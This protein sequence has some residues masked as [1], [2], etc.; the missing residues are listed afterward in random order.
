VTDTKSN[1]DSSSPA[2]DAAAEPNGDATSASSAP[3]ADTVPEGD[4][5]EDTTEVAQVTPE[6]EITTLKE[7]LLRMAADFDNYRKRSRRD[8]ADA[9]RRVQE[10]L[11]R[12]LLP[13]FDNIE[14]AALHAET[15]TDVKPLVEGL[16]MVMKQFQDTLAGLGIERVVSVGLAFDPSQHEAVQHMATSEVPPGAV[17]QELQAGYTWQGRLVRPAMV[18]VAKAASPSEPPSAD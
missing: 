12:S 10:D 3:P 6:Q 4:S 13:T 16:Q 11:V 1:D 14:R 5:E 18:V 8:V 15:A 17:T 2:A 7:R 9:E